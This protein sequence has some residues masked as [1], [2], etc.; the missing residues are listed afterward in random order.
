MSGAAPRL[1]VSN[2]V[3]EAH[4]DAISSILGESA[5]VLY[6]PGQRVTAEHLAIAEV[7]C[8]SSDL[9]PDWSGT[10][11]RVCLDAP[12]LRWLHTFSAG[13]DHPVFRMF[14]DKGVR[15]TT[16]SG[17]SA[18]PI[19]HHVMMNLLDAAR[20]VPRFLA[21]QARHEWVPRDVEDLEGRTVGV[22]GMGP[23]GLEVARLAIAFGM[24]PIGM[25]R[26]VSG[27]EPCETWTFDR[28]D[29][30]LA[31][32]DDLVLVVPLTP[33]TNGLIGAEQFAMMRP[34]TRLVNVGRGNLVDEPAMIEALRSGHLGWAALDVTSVEPLPADSPLWDMPNVVITPHSSGATRMNDV[35]AGAMFLDNLARYV[36][37]EP[38]RNEVV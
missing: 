18:V 11:L 19:A 34:G 6:H 4:G 26:T 28:L 17:S 2:A 31:I 5:P 21:D 8:L 1:F 29:D 9:W 22:I 20:D 24:R 36:R 32:V 38:M 13:I 10:Y 16:S 12:N 7:A 33:E 35:R 15:L 37:G 3:W 14:L 25:R 27:T 23:I 30:L